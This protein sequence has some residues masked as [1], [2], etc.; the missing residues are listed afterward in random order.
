ME[1]LSMVPCD[2]WILHVCSIFVHLYWFGNKLLLL[3]LLWDK[4]NRAKT[5]FLSY[6]ILFLFFSVNIKPRR[7]CLSFCLAFGLAISINILASCMYF[8][9]NSWVGG[10]KHMNCN[11][12]RCSIYS[13][14]GYMLFSYNI[15]I[16]SSKIWLFL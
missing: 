7:P 8:I 13:V 1:D 3:I 15:N 12:N 4:S 10:C 14:Y 2:W 16:H 11:G 5:C 9:I 6:F